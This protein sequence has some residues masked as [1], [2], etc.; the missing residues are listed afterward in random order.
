METNI[1]TNYLAIERGGNYMDHIQLKNKD[2]MVIFEDV[3]N[4]SYDEVK[5]YKD[6]EIFVTCVMDATNQYFNK[7]DEQTVI[8]LI[9]KDDIFVWS[10]IVGPGETDY[11]LRYVFV[12][13]RK[14]G[15]SFRY[16]KN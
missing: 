6:V 11:E 2:G 9:D 5:S 15:Q 7:D 16:E 8:T 14:D 12:D 3:I 1:V 10:I 4:M 13:W